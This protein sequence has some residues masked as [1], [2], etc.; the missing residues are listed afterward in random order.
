M[1][2]DGSSA[3]GENWLKL[4]TKS[5]AAPVVTVSTPFGPDVAEPPGLLAP[6][7]L[8]AARVATA[9]ST[10]VVGANK[11]CLCL[12]IVDTLFP[13]AQER[14]ALRH[15]S[16]PMCRDRSTIPVKC[17]PSTG[18]QRPVDSR[19]MSSGGPSW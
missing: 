12:F 13:V 11:T 19:T 1:P 10:A 4:S 3:L 2:R 5:P 14:L 7:L 15:G 8:Q 17:Q 9:R 16:N 18:R 6:P